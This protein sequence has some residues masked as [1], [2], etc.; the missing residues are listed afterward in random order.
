MTDLFNPLGYFI[1]SLYFFEQ[2]NSPNLLI[3]CDIIY[4]F[5]NK[6]GML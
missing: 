1:I 5:I 6:K 4:L 3:I 2:Q